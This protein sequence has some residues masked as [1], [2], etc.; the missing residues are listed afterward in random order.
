LIRSLEN[1]RNKG[2]WIDYMVK[3]EGVEYGEID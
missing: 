2:D 3:E 1:K